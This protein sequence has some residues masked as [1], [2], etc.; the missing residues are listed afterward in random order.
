MLSAELTRYVALQLLVL[1]GSMNEEVMKTGAP[2]IP[3]SFTKT[4]APLN[5]QALIADAEKRIEGVTMVAAPPAAPAAP[6]AAA[7]GAVPVSTPVAAPAAAPAAAAPVPPVQAA[8]AAHAPP[9][10]AP[11][12]HAAATPAAPAAHAP[13]ASPPKG[14]RKRDVSAVVSKIADTVADVSSA[15]GDSPL[16]S[17]PMVDTYAQVIETASQAVEDA[18]KSEKA[19]EESSPLGDLILSS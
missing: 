4:L 5:L 12:A 8:P 16:A 19:P 17:L 10:R 18:T 15:V 2:I 7:P 11:A 9:A 13:P 14:R 1:A 3:L 6:P